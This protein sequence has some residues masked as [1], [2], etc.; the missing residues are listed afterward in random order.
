MRASDWQAIL[1]DI[2]FVAGKKRSGKDFVCDRFVEQAGYRK[3]HIAEN[4]LRLFFE[5]RGLDPDRWEELKADYRLEIQAEAELARQENP[6]RLLDPLV[7]E[8][9]RVKVPTVVTAVR[10]INEALLGFELGALV[11]RVHTPED[12]RA[13]RFLASGEDLKHLNDSFEREVDQMPVHAAIPGTMPADWYVPA[14]ASIYE[15]MLDQKLRAQ[16]LKG[17]TR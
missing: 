1:P 3:L 4:W 2:I 15:T 8:L 10:F 16:V 11:L 5:R 7:E 12:I 9:V 14:I 13:E 17:V 6:R